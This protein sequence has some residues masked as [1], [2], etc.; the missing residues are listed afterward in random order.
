MTEQPETVPA[1]DLRPGQYVDITDLVDAPSEYRAV[2]L[3]EPT[4]DAHNLLVV[5]TGGIYG[6]VTP[7]H[8]FH[9]VSDAEVEAARQREQ[10]RQKRAKVVAALNR[11]AELVEQGMPLPIGNLSI[12][13]ALQSVEDLERVAEMLGEQ[14]RQVV[15][16]DGRPAPDIHHHFGEDRHRAAVQLF[17]WHLGEPEQPEDGAS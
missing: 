8:R 15:H 10:D 2:R 3:V 9:L 14:I 13:G 6:H 1:R 17:V 12:N 16:T 11:L 7:D 4:D 5:L